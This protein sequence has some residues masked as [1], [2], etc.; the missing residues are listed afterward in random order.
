[1]TPQI[2]QILDYVADS[3]ENYE[4]IVSKSTNKEI[5]NIETKYQNTFFEKSL[6]HGIPS[7]ILMYSSLYKI[8]KQEKYMVVSQVYIEKLVEIVSKDGIESPSLYAGTAGI[9]LAIREASLS[10]KYYTKLLNSLHRLL[11]KQI[12]EKLIISL[13]NIDKGIIEPF[14]YDMVNGFSGIVNY[15][16]L[17]RE[18]FLEELKQIGTYLLKYIETILNKVT[19]CSVGLKNGLDLGIAHGIVGPMLALAKLKSENILKEDMGI[20]NEAIKLV[21]LC[22]RDDKLWPGKIYS[23][24]IINLDF[25]NLPTRMAW[26]YG[27]PGVAFA[28]FKICQLMNLNYIDEIIES[29]VNHLHSTEKNIYSPS[30]CHG[31]AGVAFIYDFIG[32]NNSNVELTDF[33]DSLRKK[34]ITLFS[35]EKVFGYTDKE[36]IVD[37]EVNLE[38]VGI[39][40]G[41]TGIVLFLLNPYSDE[42]LLWERMFI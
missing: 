12:Q 23:N 37:V 16:I 8:T 5:T 10:G 39:L 34:I 24:N 26:C 18:Y 36:K 27:T 6:S 32:R 21:F 15:L 19:N 11:K 30:M 33:S 40:Q 42:N 4:L 31:L 29:L 1:M 3:L 22:R 41:V 38:S 28:L 17:E 25:K 14:D 2:K 20:V 9:A 13:S 7:L 35:E